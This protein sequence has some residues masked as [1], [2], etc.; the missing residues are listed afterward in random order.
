MKIRDYE[1]RDWAHICEAHD[2]ARPQE[3]NGSCDP[4]AFLSLADTAE[5]EGL[6]RSHLWVAEEDDKVI[7]FVAV[8]KNYISWLYIHPDYQRRG[9]GRQ[10]LRHAVAQAGT[11]VFVETLGG[12]HAAQKLYESEGFHIVKTASCDIEGYPSHY[13]KMVPTGD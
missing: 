6:F 4:R 5:K 12:N 11:N 2:L 1:K 13:V 7:G 3:L 10:L 8:E 9:F